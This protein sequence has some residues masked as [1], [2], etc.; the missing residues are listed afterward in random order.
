MKTIK[1]ALLLLIS[2]LCLTAEANAVIVIAAH[3]TSSAG[4][5]FLSGSGH[6]T[7]GNRNAAGSGY[8]T[9]K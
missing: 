1:S 4:T 5:G 3:H 9:G 6:H 8:G 2:L 7:A